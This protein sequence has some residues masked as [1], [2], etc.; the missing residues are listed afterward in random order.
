MFL[1]PYNPVRLA[2]E[3]ARIQAEMWKPSCR[4]WATT[5]HGHAVSLSRIKLLA[6]IEVLRRAN[7]TL[8]FARSNG[9]HP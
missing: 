1:T 4:M 2:V 9:R 7:A 6:E 5:D 8:A 3:A